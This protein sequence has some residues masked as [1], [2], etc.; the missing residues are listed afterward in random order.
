MWICYSFFASQN[1]ITENWSLMFPKIEL[2]RRR[3][4]WSLS[5]GL[6]YSPR[7]W[8][9][10]KASPACRTSSRSRPPPSRSP[11]SSPWQRWRLPQPGER[12]RVQTFLEK[13]L[14]LSE[15][16]EESPTV[17]DDAVVAG[18][19]HTEIEPNLIFRTDGRGAEVRAE[20]DVWVVS[21]I[22]L[23]IGVENVIKRPPPTPL[24][25]RYRHSRP[26][27]RPSCSH[28]CTFF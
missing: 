4:L 10:Y 25:T 3:E 27:R 13:R 12:P 7:L 26:R 5:A 19:Q 21:Q 16:S 22:F 20:V 1:I 8:C 6:R 24:S 28:R 9:Q 11:C 14:L 2:L 15:E 23:D 17:G 18:G